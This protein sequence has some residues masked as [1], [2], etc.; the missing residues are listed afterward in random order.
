ML[1]QSSLSLIIC[2]IDQSPLQEMVVYSHYN[3]M[4][5]FPA[6][7]YFYLMRQLGLLKEDCK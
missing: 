1:T 7:N 3:W 2:G 4:E 5:Q 6:I